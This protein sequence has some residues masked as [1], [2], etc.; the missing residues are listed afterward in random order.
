VL[1][2]GLAYTFFDL[3]TR[4]RIDS[5]ARYG[6]ENG[7]ST[8]SQF[9]DGYVAVCEVH[10]D[11]CTGFETVDEKITKGSEVVYQNTRERYSLNGVEPIS[12]RF[13]ALETQKNSQKE[14]INKIVDDFFNSGYIDKVNT[15]RSLFI[16]E[17]RNRCELGIDNPEYFLSQDIYEK[18]SKD[19]KFNDALLEMLKAEEHVVDTPAEELFEKIENYYRGN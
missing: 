1:F 17:W 14:M 9:D 11:S 15:L 6:Q 12:K 16:R 13:F 5:T 19:I 10:V 7:K 18:F 8:M 2:G 4:E 3:S